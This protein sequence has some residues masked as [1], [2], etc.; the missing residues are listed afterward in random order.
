MRVLQVLFNPPLSNGGVERIVSELS[1]MLNRDNNVVDILCAGSLDNYER[2]EFGGMISLKVPNYRFAGRLSV[3]FRKIHYNIRL[4]KFILENQDKYDIFHFH[5]DVGGF[6]EIA[7]LNSIATMHGFTQDAS[8][9]RNIFFRLVLYFSSIK[10]EIGNVKYARKLTAVNGKIAQ[11]INKKYNRK[12][13]VIYNGVDTHT[14]AP[15]S[16]EEKIKL[17]KSLNLYD[18]KTYVIFIGGDK[19]IKGLDIFISAVENINGIWANVLGVHS[20]NHKNIKF[21]GRVDEKTLIKYLL[22][23]DILIAPSRYDSFSISAL[24][25]ISC[26][27]PIIISNNLGLC[28]IIEDNIN[29]LIINS[30]NPDDYKERMLKLLS[31]Y[32]LYKRISRNGRKLALKYNINIVYKKYKRVYRWLF[33]LHRI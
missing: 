24:E 3:A 31:D 1:T 23:S 27:V 26:G 29:G 28:E 10:Y 5:G 15:I 33:G 30:L 13:I 14:Y 18:K 22:C 9:K 12:C 32:K 16:Q 20:K 6:K 8:S 7:N 17:R 25:S 19:Y 4:K 2:A 11:L 21:L